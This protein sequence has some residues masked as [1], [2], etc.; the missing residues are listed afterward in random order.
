M[1]VHFHQGAFLLI[2]LRD[3][4]CQLSPSPLQFR[5]TQTPFT[6]RLGTGAGC[7]KRYALNGGGNGAAHQAIQPVVIGPLWANFPF[8]HRSATTL[9]F[10][11]IFGSQMFGKKAMRFRA[12]TE[13]RQAAA[14]AHGYH[15]STLNER[16]PVVGI[17]D[18]MPDRPLSL[19]VWHPPVVTD[20]IAGFS[21]V[22]VKRL[23]GSSNKSSVTGK[24]D[25][26][27]DRL[28]TELVD[29]IGR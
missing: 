19:D 4:F 15:E 18:H 5:E 11:S 23:A 6:P 16:L 14:I 25:S 28:P 20:A 9:G 22:F 8:V 10:H 12:I 17:V 27:M 24:N 21:L 2:C 1:K 3:E 7:F 29:D 13:K 26:R